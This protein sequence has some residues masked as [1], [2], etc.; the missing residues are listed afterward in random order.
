MI[1]FVADIHAG[2]HRRHGGPSVAGLNDRCRETLAVLKQ[3]ARAAQRASAPLVLLGDTFDTIRPEPQVIAATQ[4]ALGMDHDTYALLGNHEMVSGIAGDH[5][6]GPLHNHGMT[7]VVTEPCVATVGSALVAFVPYR[8]GAASV[9]LPTVLAELMRG[10]RVDDPEEAPIVLALHLGIE[11]DSTPPWLRGAH[12]SVTL[13]QLQGLIKQYRFDAVVAGN[14]HER[15]TWNL[16]KSY[17]ECQVMQ[18]GALVP[19]GWDNPGL[20]GYGTLATFDPKA[21]TGERLSYE[22]L[23]GPRF[24][25]LKAGQPIPPSKGNKLY[26]QVVAGQD[27]A[28]LADEH[29]KQLKETGAITAGEVILDEG[30]ARVASVDAAT[31][32]R[33]EDS[34]EGALAAF[35]DK[36]QLEV[37]VDRDAVRERC[38][39]YLVGGAG[40]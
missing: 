16:G 18:V 6:L 15:R 11:S 29:L 4:E 28:Q 26:L 1:S 23:L 10:V 7:T 38:R 19:T 8:P 35:V 30:E 5:S 34:V 27:G 33:A 3:A 31:A 25:K 39:R 17:G 24:V 9:W 12:D 37:S 22:E 2:N 40:R 20:T 14:W 21:S 13:E 32:A 36:M